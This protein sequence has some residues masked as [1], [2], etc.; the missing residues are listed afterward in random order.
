MSQNKGGNK[1]LRFAIWFSG[2]NKILLESYRKVKKLHC[3]LCISEASQALL[4]IS[5][6]HDMDGC[7]NVYHAPFYKKVAPFY[8]FVSCLV[9][10]FHVECFGVIRSQYLIL[11]SHDGKNTLSITIALSLR[12]SRM[13]LSR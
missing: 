2:N 9:F 11:W 5:V 8:Y 12:N 3:H 1:F 6:I 10:L 13:M 4:I 7:I